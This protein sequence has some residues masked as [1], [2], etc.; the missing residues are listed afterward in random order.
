LKDE[1]KISNVQCPTAE[2]ND[3]PSTVNRI[4]T[5]SC[6]NYDYNEDKCLKLNVECV[7][8]R[9]GCVLEG[10]V[11]VSE[12]LEKRIKDPEAQPKVRTRKNRG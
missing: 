6:K 10:K 12:D 7:P 4:M 5:F 1:G 8:G 3:K 2:V 11:R 9:R